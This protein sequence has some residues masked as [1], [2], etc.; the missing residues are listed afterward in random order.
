VCVCVC[1]V[2]SRF[3]AGTDDYRYIIGEQR[4]AVPRLPS[5]QMST[6]GAMQSRLQ[7]DQDRLLLATLRVY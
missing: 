2:G 5:G 3:G 4:I 6:T 7:N 1:L